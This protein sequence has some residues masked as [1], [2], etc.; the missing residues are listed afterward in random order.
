MN[1]KRK[2]VGLLRSLVARFK[3]SL[4]VAYR[5]YRDINRYAKTMPVETSLGFKLVGDAGM[6]RG[7][8]ELQETD[9]V[10]KLLKRADVVVDV[11]ANVG[12]YCCLALQANKRVVAFEPMVSNLTTLYRNIC[13][14]GWEGKIEVFPLALSNKVGILEMWGNGTGASLV[15]GWAN[16]PSDYVNR[17][18]VSTLDTVLGERFKESRVLYIVD[19]EGAELAMLEGAKSI[20]GREGA[21]IWMIEITTTEHQPGGVR[22]NPNLLA[23]F[24]IFWSHGYDAWT[25]SADMRVIDI[26]EIKKIVESGIDT[27]GTHNFLFIP[28]G[29]KV[30]EL[31]DVR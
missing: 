22:I 15:K 26:S 10:K 28:K 27:L 18:P 25:A 17:V 29:Q 21:A 30:D 9:I 16:N 7:Y 14:N 20:L 1:V 19:V 13:C 11:G 31:T 24:Q 5:Q 23:T 12:Y 8:F 2:I 6:M 3:P 4:L